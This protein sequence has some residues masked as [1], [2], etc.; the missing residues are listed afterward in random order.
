MS[1][2]PLRRLS[3]I[4]RQ[5]ARLAALLAAAFLAAC[6]DVAGPAPAPPVRFLERSVDLDTL[7][8]GT[9][10]VQNTGNVP[11]G[12]IRIELT[13]LKM[14]GS[15]ALAGNILTGTVTPA[16]LEQLGP[17]ES[18]TVT[19]ALQAEPG[20]AAGEYSGWLRALGVHT[21]SIPVL[22]RV[23]GFR[24]VT[25]LQGDSTVRQGDVLV[26]QARITRDGVLLDERPSWR[27][28]PD[29]AG[30]VESTGAFVGYAT[31]SASVVATARDGAA[32][33]V[34]L[35]VTPRG[36][37][38]SML[39][40]NLGNGPVPDRFTSDL[41]VFSSPGDSR[42]QVAY[43]GTWEVR[44]APGNRVYAWDVTNP[45]TPILT[46]SVAIDARTVNDVKI[47]ADGTIA[48]ATHEGSADGLNGITLLDLADPAHPQRIT[49]YTTGLRN[50]V[51]NTWLETIGGRRYVFACHD[52]D[53]SGLK[54]ID[55]TD[56]ASP[57]TVATFGVGFSIVHDVYVRDGL[58]FVSHWNAGLVILDVGAGLVGGSPENPR[59]VSRLVPP[60]GHV[61]NAWYW[62]ERGLVFVGHEI[63]AGPVGVSSEGLISVIDVSNLQT[64]RRVATFRLSGAGPHNFWVDESAGILYS[65][66]YNAGL[67]AIDV[68]GRLLGDLLPQGRLIAQLK[69]GGPGNTYVWAPQLVGPNLVFLSDMLTGL[70]SVSVLPK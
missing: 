6:S 45:A 51:H 55:V 54:I 62:P 70:W 56:P 52:F 8:T 32:D 48:V 43:T 40:A 44:S 2:N 1:P 61:H 7:L 16:F 30:L 11:S 13:P 18:R 17:G 69:P 67:L 9:A 49:R 65:A 47:S 36:A 37:E 50:G 15:D 59:Q 26:L 23:L 25:I 29:G 24:T 66:Y 14:V 60:E 38:G 21:D 4:G 33:T 39:L 3:A 12:N 68:S 64:P 20:T 27:V 53:P 19:V 28:V 41:W 35:L 10:T 22:A 63:F 58:A 42:L 57:R 31:D 5:A 34:R 46:D